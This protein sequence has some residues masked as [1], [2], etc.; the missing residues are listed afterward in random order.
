MSVI[1]ERAKKTSV[2]ES[3]DIM[4]LCAGRRNGFINPYSYYVSKALS[5]EVVPD[6]VFPDGIA[7]VILLRFLG[8][9]AN[10][11]SFDMTSMAPVVFEYA[12]TN[13]QR[14]GFIGGSE[15]ELN[16][17]SSKVVQEYPGTIVSMA[18]CGF[19]K[20]VDD[21]L[22]ALKVSKPD[23]VIIGM[24]APLQDEVMAE[25]YK[26]YPATYFTCGGFITQSSKG[27]NYYPLWVDKLNIRFLYR[28]FKE[29][30][31]R[32]RLLLY[33]YACMLFFKDSLLGGRS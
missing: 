13:E 30:H 6:N 1:T 4:R 2:V 8:I 33:P 26:Y 17:F 16:Q 15:V 9:K 21:Y 28:A 24:G 32:K 18:E 7:L 10:R 3:G 20:T 14:V 19:G 31:Y 22:E 25:L 23:I 29:S 5:P 11:W 27:L 12:R